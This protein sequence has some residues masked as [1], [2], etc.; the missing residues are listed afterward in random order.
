MFRSRCAPLFTER[1]RIAVDEGDTL[2]QSPPSGVLNFCS[3]LRTFIVSFPILTSLDF[4]LTSSPLLY[5]CVCLFPCCSLF[6]SHQEFH[7]ANRLGRFIRILGYL[8]TVVVFT[9]V[10]IRNEIKSNLKRKRQQGAGIRSAAYRFSPRV[11]CRLRAVTICTK[12]KINWRHHRR[13]DLNRS[14]RVGYIAVSN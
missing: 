1:E 8:H 10:F 3:V 4:L 6:E 5:P 11:L 13:F 9:L 2:A 14:A 12:N 7:A